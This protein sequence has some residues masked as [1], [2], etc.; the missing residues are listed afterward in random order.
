MINMQMIM[1]MV[2][3]IGDDYTNN[4]IANATTDEDDESVMGT[5]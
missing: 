3:M 2:M 1:I 5:R 4:L